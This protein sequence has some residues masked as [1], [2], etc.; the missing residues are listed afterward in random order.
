[1]TLNAAERNAAAVERMRAVYATGDM[2]QIE[3]AAL[4]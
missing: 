1:M 4:D 3:R 2:A